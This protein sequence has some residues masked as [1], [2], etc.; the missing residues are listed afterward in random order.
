MF[1]GAAAVDLGITRKQL[2]QLRR[3]G[4]I[5]REYPDTYRLTAVRRCNEQHLRLALEWAGP[6]AAAA[7]RSAGEVY[8]FEGVRATVPE[9]VVPPGGRQRRDGI[10]VHRSHDRDALMLRSTA[11]QW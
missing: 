10:V 8:G 7:G 6:E 9:I 11:G 4:V 5:E 1:R 3:T 2:L